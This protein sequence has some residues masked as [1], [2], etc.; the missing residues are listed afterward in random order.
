M[1][2]LLFLFAALFFL[3]GVTYAQKT[4]K[5]GDTEYIF[6]SPL[7][8]VSSVV[9][10]SCGERVRIYRTTGEYPDYK[11]DYERY[12]NTFFFGVGLAIPAG[13]QIMPV[14]YGNSFNF[15]VGFKFLYRPARWYGIG[16]LFQY[17]AYSY[18]LRPEG[19]DIFDLGVATT[20]GIHYFRTDNI[21]TGFLN[22]FYLFPAGKF[23]SDDM[24]FVELGAWGDFSY[25]K[26]VKIKDFSSGHKEK[27]KYRDGSKFNP[28]E[29]GVQG[30]VGYKC[31]Y[32]Y[33]KYRITNCFNRKTLDVPEVPRFSVGVQYSYNF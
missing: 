19:K 16:T 17:S 9:R 18:K 21:G 12:I 10:D 24:A 4:V 33:C 31:V 2:K 5:I 22:R 20:N 15:E 26:R 8:K 29:A 1:K 27:F 13:G 7:K 30:G 32:I 25:S 3:A 28:F 23:A 14:Y 6:R 11:K